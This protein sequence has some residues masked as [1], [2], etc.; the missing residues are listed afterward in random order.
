MTVEFFSNKSAMTTDP[1]IVE[2][3]GR[4]KNVP[5]NSRNENASKYVGSYYY[6]CIPKSLGCGFKIFSLL[7]I[8]NLNRFN[9]TFYFIIEKFN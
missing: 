1:E 8:V 2:R 4:F 6:S 7:V 5:V 3:L 9:S